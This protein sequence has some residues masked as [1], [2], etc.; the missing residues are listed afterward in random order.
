MTPLDLFNEA[1][2]DEALAAQ[3]AI[4][5]KSPYDIAA[6]L[7]C[8]EMLAY[9]GSYAEVRKQLRAIRTDDPAMQD[10]LAGWQQILLAEQARQAGEEPAFFIPPPEAISQRWALLSEL[11]EGHDEA[12]DEL[13][14][15][16]ESSP[17]LNGFVDGREFEGLRDTDDLLAPVLEVFH[18]DRYVWVPWEH[19]RKLRLA[20]EEVLRDRIYRPAHLWLHDRSEWEILVPTLYIGTANSEDEGIKVGAG[21][22]WIET[23]LLMRGQG[24][25]TLIIGEEELVL[26]EFRQLEFRR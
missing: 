4:V 17:W 18:A 10:Y 7:L 13:D 15:L 14:A 16:E 11:L 1:R 5:T 20:E 12:L 21:T 9:A 8:C 2:F 23:G 22:D 19:V 6:R 25:K 24:G 3:Q 26:T